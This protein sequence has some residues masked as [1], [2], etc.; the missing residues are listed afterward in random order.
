MKFNQNF[1]F[2]KKNIKVNLSNLVY[3]KRNLFIFGYPK[4]KKISKINKN[5]INKEYKNIS[6]Y[7]FIMLIKNNS[8]EF[9]TDIV[10]NYRVYFKFEKE[11]LLIFDD[12]SLNNHIGKSI[13]DK[14]YFNFF[15]EKNYTPGNITFFKNIRKFQPCTHY[16]FNKQLQIN[17]KILFPNLKNNPNENKCKIEIKKHF[18]NE[19]K[20]IKNEKIILLFSGGLDSYFLYKTLRENKVKFKCA[21]FYT[22]PASYETEKNLSKVKY[23]CKKDNIPLD[24]IKVELKFM[25]SVQNFIKKKMIFNYHISLIFFKGIEYLKNKYGKNILLISGQSCDSILSFGPSQNTI[26]NFFARYLIN[27][28]FSFFAKIIPLILNIKFKLKLNNP[29][30]LKEFYRSFFKSFYYYV[31]KYPSKSK[32]F[33][34]FNNLLTETNFISNRYS[35]LMFLKC[36]GFL[37]G[38]DNMIMIKSANH[39]KISKIFLPFASYNFISIILRYYNFKKDILFPKYILKTLC[40]DYNKFE[41]KKYNFKIKLSLIDS[42]LKKIYINYLKKKY[43][44]KN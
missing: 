44:V 19:F 17:K 26:P 43:E 10:S 16:Q 5:N 41:N 31:L 37:Q 34:F 8:L 12:E 22:Y 15:I 23:I 25:Q 40:K 6:G 18:K 9:Y 14:N 42:K 11:K 4:L 20:Q 3:K 32:N 2:G 29:T 30:N 33:D 7:F 36:Y 21:Y 39:F 35:K 28:P 24:L 13:I 1:L 27:Y 38:S